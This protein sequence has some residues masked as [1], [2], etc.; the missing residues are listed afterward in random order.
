M[1][2]GVFTVLFGDR[3]L[4][5]A[6]HP[7]LAARLDGV[8]IGTGNYPGTAHCRPDEL[9]AD[10]AALKAFQHAISSRGLEISALSCHGNPLHPRPRA[11]RANHEVFVRSLKLAQALGGG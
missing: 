3:P 10:D 8:E 1:K 2:L 6:L 11:A 5:A 7:I 9:L 4:E